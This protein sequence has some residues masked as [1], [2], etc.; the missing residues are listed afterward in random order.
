YSGE[1]EEAAGHCQKGI[2]ATECLGR[3]RLGQGRIT[4][5]TQILGGGNS[6]RYLGYAYGRAG[7]RAEAEMLASAVA[8]NAFSQAL[9]FAGGGP[10]TRVTHYNMQHERQPQ[11]LR[12]RRGRRSRL[13]AIERTHT[14]RNGRYRKPRLLSPAH[15]AGS[16]RRQSCRSVR[17]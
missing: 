14:D 3:V 15:R 13:R 5:A 10:W 12:P 16:A 2:A 8:P 9:I 11:N 1:Y 7:R 6:P 17:H 4:E